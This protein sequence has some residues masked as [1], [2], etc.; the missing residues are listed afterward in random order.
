M[1]NE[2]E[3]KCHKNESCQSPEAQMDE[4]PPHTI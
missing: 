2:L 1:L 4:A 3:M